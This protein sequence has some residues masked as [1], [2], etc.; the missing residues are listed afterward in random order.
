MSQDG[1]AN[2]AKP[3]V[4]C[5]RDAVKHHGTVQRRGCLCQ[6][7]D[8]VLAPADADGGDSC[9]IDARILLQEGKRRTEVFDGLV[10]GE[11]GDRR[12][13]RP[14]IPRLGGRDLRARREVRRERDETRLRELIG[15]RSKPVVQPE[16][17]VQDMTA[18]R[19]EVPLGRAT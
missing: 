3:I 15:Q 14:P 19:V 2:R 17:I 12:A 10:R 7:P 13:L 18:G 9:G 5:G 1:R 6:F 8:A 4:V 11:T 16:I